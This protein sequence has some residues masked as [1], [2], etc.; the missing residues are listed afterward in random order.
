MER[1]QREKRLRNCNYLLRLLDE[2]FE[3][4]EIKAHEAG[5]SKAEFLRNMILYGAAHKRTLV[6]D[7]YAE[8]IRYELNRIGNN[9][10]QI[11]YWANSLKGIDREKIDAL[12]NDYNDLL[13]E[14]E[15]VISE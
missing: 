2:E 12:L 15:R 5:L 10:N 14:F 9:V 13:G 8:K 4:F 1:E 3:I 6:S 11:A 7:E